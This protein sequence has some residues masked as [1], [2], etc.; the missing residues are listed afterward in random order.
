MEDDEDKA[1]QRPARDTTHDS[2]DVKKRTVSAPP[3]WR[4]GLGV[5]KRR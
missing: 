3:R 4:D 2:L 1:K 5:R